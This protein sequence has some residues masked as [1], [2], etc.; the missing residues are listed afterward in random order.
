M[1]ATNL[2]LFFPQGTRVL[3]LPSWRCPRLYLPTRRFSQRWEESGFYPASRMSAR[4]RRLVLRIE[5]VTGVAEVRTIASSDWPLGEFAGDLLPRLDSATIL[6]SESSAVQKVTVQLRDEKRR[7]LGYLK[8]VEQGV[9]RNRLRHEHHVLCS[10]PKGTGPEALKYGPLGDGEAL[11][12]S[13]ILGKKLPVTVPPARSV[14]DFLTSLVASPPVALEAH[15]WVLGTLER[16]GDAAL[17]DCFEALAG[18]LWPITIQHGD[19][20]PWN[21][22]QKPEGEIGVFD[23]EYGTL[24]GF[25]YLDHIYYILQTTALI[26]R[27]APAKAAQHAVRYLT[28]EPR[29]GLSTAEAQALTR[30]AAYDAYHT[31]LQ[32]GQVEDTDLQVWRRAIWKG[33][34]WDA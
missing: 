19:F 23:W 8:Y 25:P 31:F 9:A 5:A 24:E 15:P 10:L 32:F 27:W 20:A 33:A 3:A 11:L 7:V 29:F 21:L 1:T 16:E 30:L 4:L 22:L 26:N 18:R 6:V 14:V 12:M 28:S 34:V 13:P 17:Q 2:G